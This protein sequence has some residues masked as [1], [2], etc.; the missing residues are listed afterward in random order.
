MPHLLAPAAFLLLSASFH[1]I[2]LIQEQETFPS[3]ITVNRSQLVDS[4]QERHKSGPSVR[5]LL[6]N[7]T[8][9]YSLC[10]FS[11]PI[12]FIDF[13]S[14]FRRILCC[15]QGQAYFTKTSPIARL[16][17]VATVTHETIVI[18]EEETE[19]AARNLSLQPREKDQDHPS[20]DKMP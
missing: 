5:P 17:P 18:V 10:N 4:P 15:D 7:S 13:L 12:N 6:P 2:R 9:C 14:S 16:C 8:T 19:E 20:K 11:E 3:S 1:Q